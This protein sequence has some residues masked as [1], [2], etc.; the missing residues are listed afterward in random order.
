[1]MFNLFQDCWNDKW[2]ERIM[3]ILMQKNH[4][5]VCIERYSRRML[6]AWSI[7]IFHVTKCTCIMG[8][9]I[10]F[11]NYTRLQILHM[12]LLHDAQ[13]NRGD[14]KWKKVHLGDRADSTLCGRPCCFSLIH[15]QYRQTSRCRCSWLRG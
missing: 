7:A 15:F 11:K 8:L 1:M 2:F 12:K 4:R 9:H 14:A 3:F 5:Q 10:Y 6:V 13:S